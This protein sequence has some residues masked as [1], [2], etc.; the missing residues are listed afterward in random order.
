MILLEPVPDKAEEGE[1]E[2][3]GILEGKTEGDTDNEL[4]GGNDADGE[5]EIFALLPLG[6][7]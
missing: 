2:G 1:V 6:S 7:C 4:E 5:V 3:E